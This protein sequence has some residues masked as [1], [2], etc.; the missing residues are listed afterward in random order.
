MTTQTTEPV[1]ATE[2]VTEMQVTT[3]AVTVTI[4]TTVDE[5]VTVTTGEVSVEAVASQTSEGS[6]NNNT[7]VTVTEKAEVTVSEGQT[8]EIATIA[9]SA[10][11]ST[12]SLLASETLGTTVQQVVKTTAEGVEVTQN[13][14]VYTDGTQITQKSGSSELEGFEE[15][16]VAVEQ[17]IQNGTQSVAEAYNDK[18]EV[19]LHQFEQVGAAVT[20][21]VVA[22]ANGAVS[23]TQMEQTSF[24]AGQEITALITD[25]TGAV[26]TVS[27]VVGENGIIQYN[28]PGVNCVV[29]YLVPKTTPQA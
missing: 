25:S 4:P 7:I 12:R 26:T 2:P 14:V 21:E 5:P 20:F 8:A 9:V 1:T 28:I 13:V 16:V 6:V 29:R 3:P 22:G 10:D 24:T 19:D 23:Q 15:T 17:A 27:L 18:V 11:G